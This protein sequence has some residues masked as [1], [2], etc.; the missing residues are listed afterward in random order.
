MT[1]SYIFQNPKHDGYN[2][3]LM[4][5]M[6]SSNNKKNFL[7]N[8]SLTLKVF[9]FHGKKSYYCSAEQIKR[10]KKKSL[11]RVRLNCCGSSKEKK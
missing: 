4:T 6:Q 11:S 7:L 5:I 3:N 1:N 9:F 10:I 2:Y 8:L